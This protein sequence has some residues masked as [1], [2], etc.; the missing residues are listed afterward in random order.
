MDYG[1]MVI[2]IGILLGAL[3]YLITIPI[4]FLRSKMF[5]F[6][7]IKIASILETLLKKIDVFL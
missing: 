1:Y 4:E 2:P 7:E 3:I 6:I 5:S